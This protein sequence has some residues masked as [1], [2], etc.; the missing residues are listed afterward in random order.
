MNTLGTLFSRS[1][2]Q[3]YESSEETIRR[4]VSSDYEVAPTRSVSADIIPQAPAGVGG[5][6]ETDPLICDT[7]NSS[8][9]SS[10]THSS[11]SECAVIDEVQKNAH[12]DGFG[13]KSISMFGGFCLLANNIT[14][15]GAFLSH[16][17]KLILSLLE[18]YFNLNQYA[19]FYSFIS[20]M[21]NIPVVYQQAGW[22]PYVS[23]T[24][25]K[26]F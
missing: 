4:V 26:L 21:V 8:S 16:L 12:A 20:A 3:D 9:C 5:G 6:S 18:N 22:L 13:D 11:L 19:L 25:I 10:S 7:S 23:F 14:G 1:K 24:T 17:Q 2:T 15:P